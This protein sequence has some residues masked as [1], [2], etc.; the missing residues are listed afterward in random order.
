MNG[1]CTNSCS[2]LPGAN[3]AAATGWTTPAT[4]TRTASTSTTI[5]RC[6]PIAQW[7]IEAFNAQHAVRSVH[8]RE[9]GRRSAAEPRRCD[10][11]IGSG[12]NRCNMTTNEGGIIDEEY[13]VLYARD[14]TETTA[15]GVAGSDRRVCRVS[16]PQVRPDQPARV[17]R[18]CRRSSTTR[19]R[20]CVTATSRTRRR[21]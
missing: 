18:A 17:L 15:A 10:Q 4:P 3:T 8:R 2:P 19:L 9:P 14:R 6:G 5:A 13:A 1:W 20:R 11:R 12:F 21:L 16:R 7:V